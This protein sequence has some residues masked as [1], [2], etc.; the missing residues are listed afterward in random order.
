MYPMTALKALSLA[1][2]HSMYENFSTASQRN[3]IMPQYAKKLMQENS[4]RGLGADKLVFGA[5]NI[6]LAGSEAKKPNSSR[7][8]HV[9]DGSG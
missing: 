4:K 2:L 6:A 3:W 5:A 8:L 7:S 9:P 1:L